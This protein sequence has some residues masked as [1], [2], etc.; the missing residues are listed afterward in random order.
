LLAIWRYEPQRGERATVVERVAPLGTFQCD[1][2]T[3]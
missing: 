2:L 1:L 3:V